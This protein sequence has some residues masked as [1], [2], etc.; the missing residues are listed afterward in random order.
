MGLWFGPEDRSLFAM[1]SVPPDGRASGA[2]VLCQPLGVEGVCTRRTFSTLCNALAAAGILTIRF[3]YDGTGDSVGSDQ[4]PDRVPAWLQSVHHAV[5]LARGAGAPKVAVVGMRLGATFAASAFGAASG[6]PAAESPD[7]MVLWDPC[8]SG[9]SYLR[10][11]RALHRLRYEHDD[12]GD[13]SIEA[14]G[15]VF[16]SET[17]A[18]LSRLDLGDIEGDLA[19][20]ILVLARE[21][22][23]HGAGT[24]ERF[25]SARHVERWLAHGQEQLVD[26]K[27]DAAQVPEGDLEAV[28]AWL[29]EALAGQRVT[30][31]FP[32]RDE[33]VMGAGVAGPVVERAASFGP[34]GL[35]G[36][37]TE[38]RDAEPRSPSA[39]PIAVFL[40]AGV[41]DHAGPSRLWVD[42][43]RRWAAHGMRCVRCDLS[44]LGDSPARPNNPTDVTH[45]PEAID[46]IL[47]LAAAISP[48]DPSD[49]VLVGLCSGGYHAIEG[50][51]ALTARGVVAMNPI[52]T[53]KPAE[54]HADK[55]TDS[56]RQ[57]APV[58]KRWVRALPAHDQLGALVERMPGPVWWL[59]NRVAI[60]RPPAR[61][62]RQLVDQGVRTFILSGERERWGMWRGES[63]TYR[64]LAA[65]AQFHHVVVPDIDHELFTRDSREVV[66]EIVTSEVLDAYV[67]GPGH[68]NPV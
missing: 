64:D 35:F 46:D 56:R 65:T 43:S 7:A 14:P 51:L 22:Q 57:A 48:D 11:Q 34:H 39:G 63:R 59:L 41:I 55:E 38:S 52:L 58:R 9:R 66:S 47:E 3:D 37:M 16:S 33:A 2:V 5:E 13:G 23:T 25:V 29:S 62:L 54:V 17:A 26:V 15:V 53:H 31:S 40:N 44:G 61:A 50:A 42:L 60:E 20:R 21:A 32:R 4:D 10:A 30:V 67:S 28:T 68:R 24:L 6:G 8:I 45:P 27:P 1:A 36:I 12:H 18:A 49:V 19:Q